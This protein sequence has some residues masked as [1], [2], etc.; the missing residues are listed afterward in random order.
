MATLIIREAVSDDAAPF[1]DLIKSVIAEYPHVDMPFMPD[2]YNPTVELIAD[3]IIKS[4]E[5][6]NAIFLMAVDDDQVIGTLICQGGKL[7]ADRHSAS[8]SIYV[9]KDWRDQHVGHAL[10]QRA[11]DWAK[12]TAIIERIHLEVYARNQR[13]IHLYEK[14][15]FELEGRKRRAYYQGGEYIDMVIMGL[16]LEPA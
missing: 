9:H 16:L 5:A 2:E 10:M 14:F 1:I 3:W 13:G 15:G 12:H 8:L 11:I 4:G 7:R 6:D